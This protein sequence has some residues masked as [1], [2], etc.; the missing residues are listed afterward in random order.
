MTPDERTA[1]ARHRQQRQRAV[2]GKTLERAALMRQRG[3]DIRD[4]CRLMIRLLTPL[5]AALRANRRARTISRDQQLPFQRLAV[6]KLYADCLV[7]ACNSRHARRTM[8]MNARRFTQQAEEPLPGVV[9][10]HHVP[11]RLRL[12]IARVQRH[13]TGV[14]AVADVNGG[15]RR[16][17]G[18]ER[19]PD[20]NARQLTTGAVGKRDSAGVKARMRGGFR[21]AGFHQMHLQRAMG[22]TRERQRKRRASHAAAGDN[23]AHERRAAAISAS[24]S[25][26]DF[27]TLAVR[28]SLPV[29]VMTISSSI[30]MPMP[31]YSSGTSASGAI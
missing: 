20:A 29:S 8:Q 4:D 21:R 18:R 25:S 31:R 7:T 30:R 15:D 13:K 3:R 6:I 27:T 14:A 16:G 5:D 26:A 12:V 10:L 11:Q 22:K 28:F 1:T 2:F 23:H 24:I 9:Q 19:L 17:A